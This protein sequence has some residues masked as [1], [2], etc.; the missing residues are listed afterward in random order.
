M[1]DFVVRQTTY[2]GERPNYLVLVA[3]DVRLDDER[4][5]RSYLYC[6]HAFKFENV[7]CTWASNQRK[8]TRFDRRLK[9]AALEFARDNVSPSER[10][11]ED[12]P[13]TFVRLIPKE[14]AA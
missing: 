3:D 11:D 10:D 1:S 9:K 8:A 5:E 13:I 7:S 2:A 6:G 12:R 14:S 4:G